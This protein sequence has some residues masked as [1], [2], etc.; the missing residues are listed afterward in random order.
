MA[1]VTTHALVSMLYAVGASADLTVAAG[2]F[3]FSAIEPVIAPAVVTAP[4]AVSVTDNLPIGMPESAVTSDR[5]PSFWDDYYNRVHVRPAVLDVGVVLTEQQYDVEVWNAWGHAVTLTTI[6]AEGD[7]GLIL[8]GPTPPAQWL[9]LEART[10]TL[11]ATRDVEFEID[12]R[13]LFLFGVDGEP[14]LAVVGRG[15]AIVLP[16]SPDWSQGVREGLS[17][18]T[19]VMSAVD[20]TEQRS[21]LR[22]QPRRSYSMTV[23][24]LDPVAVRRWEQA[25]YRQQPGR[26]AVPIW[27]DGQALAADLPAGSTTISGIV[28]SGLDF[29]DGGLAVLWRSASSFEPVTVLTVASTSIELYSATLA[30]W[31][32]GTRLYPARLARMETSQ[33]LSRPIRQVAE[34][35]LVVEVLGNSG[36]Q[37]ADSGT[38]YRGY[39]VLTTPPHEPSSPEETW[40][41]TVTVIDNEIAQPLT[42]DPSGVPVVVKPMRWLLSSRADVVALRGWLQARAGR[43]VPFWWPSWSEDFVQTRTLVAGGQ[44]L[45]VA[46][47]GY[48]RYVGASSIRRDVRLVHRNGTVFYRRITAAAEV[49][50]L[51]ETIT[52][53]AAFPY[54]IDPGDVTISFL[55]LVRLDSDEVAI[56]WRTSTIAEVSVSLRMVP[57]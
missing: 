57:Q 33:R 2:G 25:L 26:W 49:D 21:R 24:A 8:D 39:T 18:K 56:D 4:V 20:G 48:A 3:T 36:L 10:Y 41:R 16:L 5:H 17:W 1:A 37:A 7:T 11:T 46:K 43:L 35:P 52:V 30:D 44:V 32:S 50:D 13:Y 27:T 15:D 23:R 53:D 51:E 29:I 12:A 34:L 14:V 55:H 19:D 54:D 28:T 45:T 31:P 40:S 42:I 6:S 22:D 9:S 47:V 38:T